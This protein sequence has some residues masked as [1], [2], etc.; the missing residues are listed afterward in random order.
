MLTTS[1]YGAR[2]ALRAVP[3]VLAI[4]IVARAG[5]FAD[6]AATLDSWQSSFHAVWQADSCASV[7]QSWK[8]YWGKVHTFY[9]GERD[10]AGWFSDSQKILTHVTDP[11]ANA[12]V[13]AQLTT[14]GRRVGG[15]WAKDDSC[16]KVRTRDTWMERAT[17]GAKPSLVG[18]Q[19]QLDKAAAADTGNGASIENAVKAINAQLDTIGIAPVTT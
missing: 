19:N 9:F 10:Y 14:L 16:R 4:L 18:W 1:R 2:Q 17:E 5:C 11:T 13:A 15:E 7:Y 3:I 6:D 8:K 12:A